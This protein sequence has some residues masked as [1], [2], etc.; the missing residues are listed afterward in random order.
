[1][2]WVSHWSE[3]LSNQTAQYNPP[4]TEYKC[5]FRATKHDSEK[6][7][8][9]ENWNDFTLNDKDIDNIGP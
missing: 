7:W 4:H 6:V 3:D 1:M 9:R 2:I 5:I 8:A